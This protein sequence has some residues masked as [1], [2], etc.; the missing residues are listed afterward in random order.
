MKNLMK[1]ANE[2]IAELT[3]IG[4]PIRQVRNWKISARCKRTWGLCHSLGDGQFDITIAQMLLQDDVS[5]ISVK[6]TIIH[7]LLHTVDGCMN[8]GVKWHRLAARVNKQYP[9]YNI[10]SHTP[11]N[12]KG[13]QIA[14]RYLFRCTGCGA[15]AGRHRK[16]RFVENYSKYYCRRCG[17]KFERIN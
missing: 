15:T 14:Y 9:R 11:A 1:L 3:A 4:I 6:N 17:G 10:Q 7:E 2:C 16:S 8:H 13:V 5:D 12:E